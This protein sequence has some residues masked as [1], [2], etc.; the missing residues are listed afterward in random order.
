MD[1]RR[2]VVI[3]SR[4]DLDGVRG[5]TTVAIVTTRGRDIPT[6]VPVDERDGLDEAS[7]INCD[8][9][10]TIAKGRLE[11]R[12]GHLSSEKLAALHRA[13][14]FALALPR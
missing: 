12:I 1:K 6:E 8:E 7:V 3:A 10:A 11:R 5:R 14:A 2:P 13:L 4:N 9:L